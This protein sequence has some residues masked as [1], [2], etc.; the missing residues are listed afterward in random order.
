MNK[1]NYKALP[2]HVLVFCLAQIFILFFFQ[3]ESLAVEKL[4]IGQQMFIACSKV[5][6]HNSYSKFSPVLRS[7]KFGQEIVIIELFKKFRLPNSDYS[8]KQKLEEAN[9]RAIKR[10][11]KA[12]I[13]TEDDY[14]RYA[15]AKIGQ[16]EFIPTSC[17]VTGDLFAHQTKDL[18]EKKVMSVISMK[19][20]RN[21]S[22]D[23]QG[24]MRA[25]RGAAGKASG[26]VADFVLLDALISRS[27]ERVNT[28]TLSEFRM[29]GQ[30]GE[31]K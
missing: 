2:L 13:I 24:D 18:A 30:L 5:E 26:G 23:E 1:N 16:K 7:L 28:E 20:K 10:N 4:T 27:E 17:L 12:K 19:A 31:F 8:S 14:S 25:M 6:S 22:D 29:N 21:F 11:L 3:K 15:W 9:K